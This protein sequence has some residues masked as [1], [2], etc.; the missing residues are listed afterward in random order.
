MT[1]LR[2]LQGHLTKG[3]YEMKKT[4]SQKSEILRYLQ[5][6]KRGITS[7]QAIELFGATRLSDIIFRLRKEGWDIETEQLVVRNRYG[8]VTTVARYKLV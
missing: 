3:E 7:L 8:H 2:T 4:K 6:H 5:T 1:P